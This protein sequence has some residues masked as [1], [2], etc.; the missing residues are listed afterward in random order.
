MKESFNQIITEIIKPK[1]TSN[2]FKK[3]GNTFRKKESDFILIF[4]IWK[5]SWNSANDIS[6]WFEIG[7]FRE[8]FYQFIFNEESKK[9]IRT[10]H[11][12]LRLHSGSIS[13]KGVPNYDYRLFENNA[14]S[15]RNGIIKDLDNSILPF[16]KNLKSIEDI[17]ILEEKEPVYCNM[18]KLFV[19]FGLSEKGEINKSKT[20]IQEYLNNAKYPQ[21]W[22]DRISQFQSD[23]QTRNKRTNSNF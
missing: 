17:L 18:A 14:E 13:N 12:S 19:G 9:S 3:Y 22:I 15:L 4:D 5:S 6:F 8:S 16:L 7:I 10:N 23:I 20:L 21:N 2:G 11:C 1:L